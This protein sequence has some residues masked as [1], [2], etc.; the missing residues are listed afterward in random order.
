MARCSFCGI[1]EPVNPDNLYTSP[2]SSVQYWL[3]DSCAEIIEHA[4]EAR[5]KRVKESDDSDD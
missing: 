4:L 3:C 1:E 2:D 5:I